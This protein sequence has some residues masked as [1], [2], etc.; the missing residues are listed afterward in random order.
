MG[1]KVFEKMEREGA[2]RVDDLVYSSSENIEAEERNKYEFFV[3]ESWKIENLVL[4]T[5]DLII[6]S[7][8]HI[9][10]MKEEKIT[11]A[12]LASAA[13]YFTNGYG[14]IRDKRGMNVYVGNHIPPKGGPEV[15]RELEFL[16]GKANSGNVHPY[17][18][19]Q[20]FESLHPLLDGNGR[21]GRLLWLWQMEKQGLQWQLGF[22]HRY[23]Y[24]SLSN[25]RK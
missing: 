14:K 11:V 6:V 23:Y 9:D 3:R 12:K 25:W 7:K 2:F 20:E 8:Y 17:E 10:F 4:S 13:L 21:V 1:N 15:V 19:H 5:S 22:L 18:V 24:Q 16:C